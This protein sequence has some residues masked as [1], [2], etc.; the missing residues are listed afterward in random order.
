[1]THRETPLAP[2]HDLPPVYAATYDHVGYILWGLEKFEASID[3]EL[4]WLERYPAFRIGW[5]HEVFAYDYVAE[6]APALLQKL[7]DALDRFE[8]RLGVGS[9][10]YGQPLSMF[11]DGESNIR[12]LTVAMD[13][14][15]ALLDYPLSV[16]IMSEHPFHAQMPQ[17]LAGC[18]FQGAIMRTH[19]MMYGHNP[20]YDAPVGWWVGV[21][22]S[23]IPTVPTYK[24]QL[25]SPLFQYKI[26]GLTSTVDNRIMTDAITE[27]CPLT[28][29]DFRR[30]FGE[31][32]QPLVATRADDV[33]NRES[34][35]QAHQDDPG[36]HWILVDDVFDRLPQPRAQFRTAPNDFRVRMPWGYC[37]NWMW[38][39]C[40]EAEVAVL[41]AERLAAIQ[42]A[43]AEDGA[44]PPFHEAALT[45]A[46]KHLMVAQHHDI[47]IC[48]LEDDAR[49]Y[50][51]TSLDA[52]QGVID[53]ALTAV[54]ARMEGEGPVVFNPLSWPREAWVDAGDG[55]GGALVS[56]PALGFARVPAASAP[57]E[58][59]VVAFRW[60]PE[61]ACDVLRYPVR[62]A[63]E[64]GT[65]H[66][67]MDEPVGHL[68]T[69]FY[70]VYLAETGGVRLLFERETDQR[71]WAP[72]RTSGSLAGMVEG[73]DCLAAGR[74]ADV[75]L[76][77]HRA[78]VTEVGEIGGI[79]YTATWT[80]YRHTR[81]I[82]WH[83]EL[84]FAGEIIGRPK[85][86]V[87]RREAGA[88]DAWAAQAVVPAYDDHEYKL[89]LRFYPYLGPF[90]T[91]VRDLPFH[92][93]ETDDAYVNG[94]YW[95]A[96]T[97]GDVG[98]AIFNRGLMGSVR[99]ADGALS[100]PLAFSLP[101]VWHTRILKG[102]Y[103]YDLG[104]LPFRGPWQETDLHRQAMA[105]NFPVVVAEAPA[106]SRELGATWTPYR[107]ETQGRAVLSA[108]YTKAGATYARFAEYGGADA[109]VA[110]RW[111]D[112]PVTLRAVDYRERPDGGLGGRLQL[113][114]WQVQTV[115]LER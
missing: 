57:P 109:S 17:L 114:P 58:G 87:A 1:M 72:P 98:L 21:D 76:D 110:F 45:T 15:E 32:I 78:V 3:K 2:E 60:D 108:L 55:K 74:V 22:G 11:I 26:P 19:F 59:D 24:G 105:Y 33:R 107:A 96:V 62:R 86:P 36:Y 20:A 48:G 92:I 49:H 88:E 50:L 13:V 29:T 84:T 75:A 80:F 115:A 8:G 79:P 67:W 73:E 31:R 6:H 112:A 40:R 9:C 47:Q 70:D 14:T 68:E 34:L 38:N 106:A 30:M 5:D 65:E 4:D 101:Y 56:V 64:A 63:T 90:T 93:A 91:G 10:T 77:P 94:L 71:L 113:S 104:L 18:G 61:A 81:R 102:T 82:D 41:T 25:L 100:V 111:L 12:Q 52:A 23:S 95:T 42:H 27:D 43:L 99:E 97:D 7:R 103:T 44:E 83:G 37:G 51:G 66:V 89:R 53:A 85:V 46:W 16:Y 35:I 28:L 39:R 54:G 69:P